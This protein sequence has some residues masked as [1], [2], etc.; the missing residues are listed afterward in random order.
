MLTV[1][2]KQPNDNE[3]TRV[4]NEVSFV[5]S[6]SEWG[7]PAFAWKWMWKPIWKFLQTSFVFRRFFRLFRSAVFLF[8][9][10]SCI[11]N[12]SARSSALGR[13]LFCIGKGRGLLGIVNNILLIHGKLQHTVPQQLIVNAARKAEEHLQ[14]LWILPNLALN[15]CSER[16]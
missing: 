4:S 3:Y 1:T 8:W 10:A 2:P 16:Y 11:L 5:G 15:R 12:A 14:R 13:R 6:G 9:P 7:L